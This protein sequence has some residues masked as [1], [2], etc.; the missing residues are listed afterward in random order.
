ML[1]L[2]KSNTIQILFEILNNNSSIDEITFIQYMPTIL[3]QNKI[4][5]D[6][7]EELYLKDALNIR[8]KYNLSFWESLLLTFFNK[9]DYP[10]RF[11]KEIKNHHTN[12]NSFT[13]LAKEKNTIIDFYEKNRDEYLALSS[14]IKMKDNTICHLPM[15]D[16]H[17]PYS[18]TN[19]DLIEDVLT[20]LALVSGYIINSG[21]SFHFIGNQLFDDS[22]YYNFL[23]QILLFAPVVDKSWVAH[24]M[25]EGYCALRLTKK[26]NTLPIL[27]KI[28][29]PKVD[30]K[31]SI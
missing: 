12:F 29:F 26:N 14:K 10:K 23:A 7:S 4:N 15:I 13:F 5:I 3:L 19:Q 2:E 11:F 28:L 6:A 24:Q 27:T 9:K 21:Q 16:F 17:V 31:S 18:E 8:S 22:K 1:N 30:F 20:E 25:I